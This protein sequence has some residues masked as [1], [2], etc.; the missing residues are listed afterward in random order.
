[1]S[2]W[3]AKYLKVPFPSPKTLRI[4]LGGFGLIF[5][6]LLFLEANVFIYLIKRNRRHLEKI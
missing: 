5:F 6:G 3:K 2:A 1:M 4:A